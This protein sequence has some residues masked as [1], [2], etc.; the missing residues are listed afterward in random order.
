[1]P[2]VIVIAPAMIAARRNGIRRAFVKAGALSPHTAR[3]P[4][5]IGIARGHIFSRMIKGG[6]LM[7]VPGGRF[8]FDESADAAFHRRARLYVVIAAIA[9]ALVVSAV[10]VLTR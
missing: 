9:A 3:T 6:V 4:D 2:P 7:E 10:L 1:M 5:E 8:W